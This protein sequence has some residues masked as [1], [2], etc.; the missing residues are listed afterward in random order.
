MLEIMPSASTSKALTP[1]SWVKVPFGKQTFDARVVESHRDRV[2]VEIT[3]EG[4][5]E[6]LVTSYSSDEIRD[7]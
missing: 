3:I 1:G 2:T 6:P 4:A 5:S 7:Q